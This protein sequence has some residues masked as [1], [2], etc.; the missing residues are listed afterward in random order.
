M[1][2]ILSL[3][4]FV[5]IFTLGLKADSERLME[6]SNALQDI[7]AK[8]NITLTLIQRSAAIAVFPRVHQAGF[9]LGAMAGKGVVIKRT[10]D[11]WSDPF[12]I[13]IKGG[14]LGLQFGYQQGSIVFFILNPDIA[15]DITNRKITLD[16]D[17]SI[18]AWTLGDNYSDS[19]DFKFTSDIYVFAKNKGIFAGLSFGG[20]VINADSFSVSSSDY[21]LKRWNDTVQDL[22]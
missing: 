3:M 9:V 18:T 19:T 11:G 2:K 13:N 21:A 14:S 6:A 20:A 16:I 22:K 12:G 15:K 17:A 8:K 1:K 7:L 5:M 10:A 4:V